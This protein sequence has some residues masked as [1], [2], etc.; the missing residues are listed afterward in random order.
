MVV[1][2]QRPATAN[3]V[4]FMLLEDERGTINL[5]V[6]PPV[7]ER[8]RVAIRSSGFVLAS[9]RLEH[10]EGTTNVLVS[11]IERLS[12][13]AGDPDDLPAAPARAITPPVGRETGQHETGRSSTERPRI[14][15][16]GV[17]RGGSRPSRRGRKG[18]EDREII[19]ELDRPAREQ[20]VAELAAAVPVG[21]S[22][23]RRGR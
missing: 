5:I 9:G 12:R 7:V 14:E 22:F 13:A 18:R 23:G 3:G 1:A 10:R 20:I 19:S 8:C 6:P 11:S 16:G 2:R 4:V 21:H 15:D 17:W